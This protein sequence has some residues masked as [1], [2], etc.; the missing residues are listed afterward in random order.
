MRFCP[1]CRTF[2]DDADLKFCPNDGVPLVAVNEKNDLWTEGLESIRETKTRIS[3][4]TRKKQIKKIVTLL[5]TAILTVMIISVITINGWLY[6]NP[7]EEEIVQND[8]P[9]PTVSPTFEPTAKP[10]P[11]IIETVSPTPEIIRNADSNDKNQLR[12]QHKN[13]LRQQH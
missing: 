9:S 12:Q 2:Y 3:R 5:I 13:R 7:P 1:K 6:F 8:F 11:T 4:E 10:I